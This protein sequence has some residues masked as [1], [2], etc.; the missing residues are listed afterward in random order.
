MSIDPWWLCPLLAVAA[1]AAAVM[2][3]EIYLRAAVFDPGAY[4][5]RKP[6]S[7]GV[8]RPSPEGTPGIEVDARVAINRHGLRGNRLR[9]GAMPRLL[10]VGGSTTEETLLNDADTWVG[11]LQAR[12][13]SRHPK[14]WVGNMGK[15]GTT[16]LHHALQL[17]RM[18]PRLPQVRVVVVLCGLN[19]ML[20]DSGMHGE[21]GKPPTWDVSQAFGYVPPSVA[22]VADRSAVCHFAGILYDRARYTVQGTRPDLPVFEMGA[23]IA[24]FKARRRQVRPEDWITDVPD[25]AR[26]LDLYRITLNHIADL[27]EGN[28]ATLVLATQPSIWQSPTS[29]QHEAR[30][31]AGGLNDPNHWFADPRNRWFTVAVLHEMLA[32]YN[33]VLREVCAA[34]G[35]TCVDLDRDLPK[36]PE[37]FFDDF[38]FSRVGATRVGDLVCRDLLAHVG[39]GD[40]RR[41]RAVSR[42]ND[43]RFGAAKPASAELVRRHEA[44]LAGMSARLAAME[45]SLLER[46]RALV[47]ARTCVS[48]VRIERVSIGGGQD[49]PQSAL[50][51]EI[52][53]AHAGALT[54]SGLLTDAILASADPAVPAIKLSFV[55][56]IDGGLEPGKART[57][58][59]NLPDT[60]R[61]L[62]VGSIAVVD[63]K[64]MR[65][66][67]LV[68]GAEQAVRASEAELAA[69]R[70]GLQN[71]AR[72][73]DEVRARLFG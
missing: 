26:P 7:W 48:R 56:P 37:N 50:T 17:E 1:L 59:C 19:D 44:K 12:L 67:D 62:T 64:D 3:A 69:L 46:Q 55:I 53:I 49:H 71:A 70:D 8:F 20:Y 72:A 24:A 66:A 2:A 22:R 27:C 11:Q 61:G 36:T 4:Y 40:E 63:A 16:A 41:G 9:R 68:R 54:L 25:L 6:G 34:R 30:L 13:R 29:A 43:D 47:D 45:K 31:Y 10:A 5:P 21:P 57:V 35:L 23:A 65:G 15:S 33:Q 52:R 32:A 18:L 39:A 60:L 14:A 28:G 38:H 51:L 58:T 42:R 73:L